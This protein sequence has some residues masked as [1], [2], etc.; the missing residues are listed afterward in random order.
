MH[1]GGRVPLQVARVCRCLVPHHDLARTPDPE[2]STPRYPLR[3]RPIPNAPL[4]FNDAD[5]SLAF[6]EYTVHTPMLGQ[7][8]FKV[9][10]LADTSAGE[11]VL[12]ILTEPVQADTEGEIESTDEIPSRVVRELEGMAQV[13]SPYVVRIVAPPEIVKI[14]TDAYIVYEEPYYSGGTLQDRLA[15]GALPGPEAQTLVCHLLAAVKD[16]W[17]QRGI[18]HRD[19]KPGNIAYNAQGDAVLLDLGIALYTALSGLTSSFDASPRTTTYAAP[20]QFELRRFSSIDFRTDLFQIGIVA[21]E[22]VAGRHPFLSPGQVSVEAY[23]DKLFNSKP[24]D[25]SGLPCSP[26]LR[27]VI[28]RLLAMRPNGRYRS[29]DEPLS[30]LGWTS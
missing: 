11:R 29:I 24:I 2:A 23:I 6:P 22:A 28:A 25:T 19:I 4:R 20:E 13:S 15:G 14:G 8:S 10:Y 26:E 3:S 16:L 5:V 21:Y 27:E 17:D 30:K 18:V 1:R 12:K 7:G 9:A